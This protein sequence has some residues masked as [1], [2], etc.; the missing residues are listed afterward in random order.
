MEL[1][2]YTHFFYYSLIVSGFVSNFL[3]KSF[4]ASAGHV[5]LNL[6]LGLFNHLLNKI[7]STGQTS[8]CCSVGYGIDM[9]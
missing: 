7:E 2:C 4:Q 6:S 3:T 8:D 5:Q 9:V 1:L